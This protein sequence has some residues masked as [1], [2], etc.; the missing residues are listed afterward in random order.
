MAVTKSSISTAA[1][2]G[3]ILIFFFTAA[4]FSAE[5]GALRRL[6]AVCGAGT[7]APLFCGDGVKRIV[8]PSPAVIAGTN[9]GINDPG[10]FRYASKS[11]I[12]SEAVA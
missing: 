11:S 12:I 3:I 6:I 8:S 4:P 5:S 10:S 9:D 1:A 7:I 2:I